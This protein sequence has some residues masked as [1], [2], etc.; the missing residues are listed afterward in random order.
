MR[1]IVLGLSLL[2]ATTAFAQK[3]EL[4]T[5]KKIYDKGQVAADDITKF[6]TT[7][8]SLET[9]ATTAEDKIASKYYK[10]MLP[11]VEIKTF[12]SQPTASQLEQ[13]L[14]PEVTSILVASM[15]E[16]LRYEASSDKK[17]FT[18]DINLNI[19]KL[20]PILTQIALSYNDTK[21]FKQASQVF[22]SIFQLDTKNV[23][24][25]ENA[26]ITAIQSSDF[27]NAEKLYREIKG[28]GFKGTGSEKFET[29]EVGV[30]KV[31]AAIAFETKNYEQAKKEYAIL[32][33]LEPED[34]PALINEATCYFYT[35][36]LVTYQ[37]MIQD[38]LV[39]DPNNAQL[40]YNVGFLSLTE[41][42]KL[43]NEINDNLKN[44]VKY[45]ELM[46]KRKA[47]FA[48]ALPY[49]ER[50]HQLDV[51]NEE[52]K[53]ILRLTYETLGMKDKAAAVK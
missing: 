13:V 8:A 50:A 49:F 35:N 53:T 42:E 30:A 44:K 12:G 22:Y 34:I 47:M 25:L 10:A 27:V 14:T 2:V 26:A 5:L 41:D 45:D 29:T 28:I 46:A 36:D 15:N 31:L 7:L 21:K 37:K 20:K 51:T 19:L 11:M 9:V 33:K 1:K 6:K 4:K 39:K 16:T 18:S 43:V 52:T 40:Q 23:A 38:V 48:N 24:N 3:D 32:N 17:I